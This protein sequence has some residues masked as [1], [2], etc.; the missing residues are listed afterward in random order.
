MRPILDD[1][2]FLCDC[3][4]RK[5]WGLTVM[6]E[7]ID[8][9][10]RYTHPRQRMDNICAEA[11]RWSVNV[12][13]GEDDREKAIG[14]SL[15]SHLLREMAKAAM[16]YAVAKNIDPDDFEIEVLG[17]ALAVVQNLRSALVKDWKDKTLDFWDSHCS[18]LDKI[19]ADRWNTRTE[20]G[21]STSGN[22]HPRPE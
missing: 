4:L 19:K 21:S 15:Y 2:Q 18:P 20:K 13:L 22:R 16:T 5:N 12:A 9:Y 14:R 17:G 6:D 10:E 1:F 11:V 3:V 7:R 8:D